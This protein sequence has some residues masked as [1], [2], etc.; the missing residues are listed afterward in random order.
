MYKDRNS[1]AHD[2]DGDHLRVHTV[3]CAH[4]VVHADH[5]CVCGTDTFDADHSRARDV[6][7]AHSFLRSHIGPE[8]LAMDSQI[9]PHL[10]DDRDSHRDE[11]AGCRRQWK[12][13]HSRLL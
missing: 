10:D 6:L 1:H 8:D 5:S 3:S 4:R 2:I 7:Y 11:H 13:Q 9:Q 12:R